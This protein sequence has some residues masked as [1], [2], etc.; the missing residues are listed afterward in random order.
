[1]NL[2]EALERNIS[3]PLDQQRIVIQA[4]SK[5]TSLLDQDVGV[6]GNDYVLKARFASLKS[7]LDQA[8]TDAVAH[9]RMILKSLCQSSA[10]P[11]SWLDLLKNLFSEIRSP[12]PSV[13]V[14]HLADNGKSSQDQPRLA[15]CIAATH[16]R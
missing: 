1:M 3:S 16:K 8:L 12:N 13:G 15:H 2:L 7:A 14:K 11:F 9:R 4:I 5:L 6:T 10:C